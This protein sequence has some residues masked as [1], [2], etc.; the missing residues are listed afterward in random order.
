MIDERLKQLL[1]AE[2]P[3]F[4][5][6]FDREKNNGRV[7]F[8]KKSRSANKDFTDFSAAVEA[9]F[10][11]EHLQLS[12][13]KQMMELY[14]HMYIV[15]AVG[16]YDIS[17]SVYV[18]WEDRDAGSIENGVLLTDQDLHERL[19]DWEREAAKASE[20]GWFFCS[21]HNRAEQLSEYDFFW[22]SSR[23]CKE[24]GK[25]NPDFRHEA[26]TETYH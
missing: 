9:E 6:E 22:F 19:G 10:N 23:Y 2:Y 14:P 3:L 4:N 16:R 25:A 13:A 7:W 24:F 21:G 17:L 11:R 15:V 26:V 20:E 12:L 8:G 18:K 5:F 1:P